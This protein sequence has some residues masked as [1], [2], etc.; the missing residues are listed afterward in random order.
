VNRLNLSAE[1][2]ARVLARIRDRAGG[3]HRRP[4]AGRHR[5]PEKTKTTEKAKD[6]VIDV[7][8][9]RDEDDVRDQDD[10]RDKDDVRAEDDVV[11]DEK[12]VEKQ[13]TEFARWRKK[14]R[15]QRRLRKRIL[16]DVLRELGIVLKKKTRQNESCALPTDLLVKE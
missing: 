12:Q 7:D 4:H 9:V 8:D 3:G 14:R 13:W 1:D 2:T 11:I 15:R 16:N 10:V 6:D 5:R